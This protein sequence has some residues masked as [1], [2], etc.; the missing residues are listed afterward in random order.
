MM[1]PLDVR[2]WT[3][4]SNALGRGCLRPENVRAAEGGGVRLVLPAGVWDGGQVASGERFAGGTFAAR[5]RVALAPGSL[6]AFFLYEDV[7][8]EANDELDVEVLGDGSR[9]VLLSCWVDGVQTHLAERVLPFDPHDGAHEYRIG[10]RPGR[11][12]SFGADGETLVCWTDGVPARP[13]RLM[14]SAWW[15]RWLEG[16]PSAEERWAL[17]AGAWAE[18]G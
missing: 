12:A 1:R 17:L 5:M 4:G 18:E 13:M 7:P 2:G 6:S 8:G 3:A 15:P 16:G 11:E 10:W 9:R 14:A